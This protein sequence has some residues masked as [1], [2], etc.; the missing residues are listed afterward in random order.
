MLNSLWMSAVAGVGA[1]LIGVLIMS[2]IKIKDD[3]KMALVLS[4]SA[5]FMLA[6]VAFD[7][8]P[9]AIAKAGIWVF[10]LSLVVGL[11]LMATIDMLIEKKVSTLQSVQDSK[12]KASEI[13]ILMAMCLHNLP[14]GMA[15]GALE[16]AKNAI[17][18]TILLSVHNIFEG[19]AIGASLQNNNEKIS[20]AVFGGIL[21]GLPTVI[22]AMIGYGISNIS[23]TFVT[24]CLALS[25]SAMIYVVF[26]ELLA[27]SYEK[28][29]KMVVGFSTIAG[30]VI[31]MVII[32][33][34]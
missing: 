7:M 31:G 22:G 11:A 23:A 6:L 28:G 20:T 26:K 33:L 19:M 1:T 15:L 12:S 4:Y 32:Y 17:A 13:L 2:L 16:V 34:V 10:T 18:F 24:I 8:I 3:Q 9:E 14:E 30:L 5:G 29:N 27:Q 21:A 25:S